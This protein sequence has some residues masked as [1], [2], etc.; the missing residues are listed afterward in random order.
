M[1]LYN[2]TENHNLKDKQRQQTAVKVAK[3]VHV[4]QFVVSFT[5]KHLLPQTGLLL[6]SQ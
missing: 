4:H 5:I 6:F 1:F 3:V 2:R